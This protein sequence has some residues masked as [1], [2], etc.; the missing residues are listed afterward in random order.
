M[1]PERRAG[2]DQEIDIA[3]AFFQVPGLQ[4]IV[5][6]GCNVPLIVGS[7]IFTGGA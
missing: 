6:S 4:V 2:E 1:L 3:T 5:W 7:E